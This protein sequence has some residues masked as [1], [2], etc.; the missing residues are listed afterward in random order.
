MQDLRSK[1][2]FSFEDGHAKKEKRKL[3]LVM[4]EA[5]MLIRYFQTKVELKTENINYYDM[6]YTILSAKVKMEKNE[7]S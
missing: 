6:Y 4:L 3:M 2:I 5:S 1:N 7:V